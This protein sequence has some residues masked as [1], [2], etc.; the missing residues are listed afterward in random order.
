MCELPGVLQS[1]SPGDDSLPSWT[2]LGASPLRASGRP[3]KIGCLPRIGPESARLT[4]LALYCPHGVPF[5]PAI[6]VSGLAYRL[7]RLSA[8]QC[9][10]SFAD[11]M[12]YFALC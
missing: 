8:L 3:N 10:L 6:I 1:A 2:P 11:G 7:L 12:S 4:C 5:G 9:L